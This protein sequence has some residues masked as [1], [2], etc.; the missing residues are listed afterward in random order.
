MREPP[1]RHFQW[2]SSQARSQTVST[3]V[4]HKN[5]T[6]AI[7]DPRWGPRRDNG[8][9]IDLSHLWP[10]SCGNPFGDRQSD[11]VGVFSGGRFFISMV[12]TLLLVLRMAGYCQRS[13][14]NTALPIG[15]ALDDTFTSVLSLSSVI[16]QKG[17]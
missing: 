17:C 9:G 6:S 5:P 4:T 10:A 3:M 2:F 11:G 16:D 14:R 7:D 1:A 13:D 15:R 8:V 12:S